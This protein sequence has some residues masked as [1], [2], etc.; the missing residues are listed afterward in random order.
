MEKKI[1]FVIFYHRNR[2]LNAALSYEDPPSRSPEE[3]EQLAN[4][5]NAQKYSAKLAGD[6][7]SNLYFM[8]FIRSL[9]SKAMLA[10]VLGIYEF[11]FEIVLVETGHVMKIYYKVRFS[12][13]SF[14]EVFFNYF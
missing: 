1:Q 7:S 2:V 9:K 8:Q 5:C 14:I 6:D 10:S 13:C 4:V 3:V 11:N 12:N